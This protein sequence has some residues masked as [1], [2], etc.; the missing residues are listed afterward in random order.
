M[1]RLLRYTI[2]KR[3]LSI[4]RLY[5]DPKGTDKPGVMSMYKRN[6]RRMVNINRMLFSFIIE[7]DYGLLNA[8]HR[9]RY[10]KYYDK[11]IATYSVSYSSRSSKRE[12]RGYIS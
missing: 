10:A 3:T 5:D 9:K 8:M 4:K 2:N 12:N 7:I 6:L 1:K 11:P